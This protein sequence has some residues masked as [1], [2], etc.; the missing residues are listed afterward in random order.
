MPRRNRPG[1]RPDI[2]IKDIA[3]R[4]GVSHATVS[5]A[6]NDHPSTSAA[7]KVKVREAAAALG[8]IRNSAAGALSSAR[9][10][11]IG[12][13]AP[14][15]QNEF[16]AMVTKVLSGVCAQAGFQLAVAVAE[17][18]PELE[19]R[20]VRGLREGRAAGVIITPTA[21]LLQKTVDLLAPLPTVQLV[22]SHERLDKRWVGIDD[23]TGVALATRHLLELGHR[24]IGFIGGWEAL[25]TGHERRGGYVDALGEFGAPYDESLVALG[26]P[27]ASFGQDAALRLMRAQPGIT[28]LVLGSSQL[29]M[30]ALRAMQQRQLSA[31]QNVS[32]VGYSDPDW[33]R[34]WGPGLTTID[35]PIED[36]AKTAAQV[37]FRLMA[38]DGV[39]P[40]AG[41]R[42][43]SFQPQLVER[44]STAPPGR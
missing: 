21:G 41:R 5:R 28:G 35:L 32:I 4:L 16:Y 11:L 37:L 34:L 7:T 17:D 23:R 44:G 13:I 2:T 43:L 42:G 3:A 36:I 40:G 9:S 29:T 15:V 8:Y 22:R 1:D 19:Y 31:P 10:R 12:F 38:N 26:P 30:G 20:L 24:R 33:F 25:T 18:D 14:D 39:A 27:L 6:L